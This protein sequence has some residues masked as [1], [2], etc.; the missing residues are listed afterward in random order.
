MKIKKGFSIYIKYNSTMV[1][2]KKHAI[3]LLRDIFGRNSSLM[4]RNSSI[5]YI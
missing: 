3:L 2:N 1:D 5:L 4:C